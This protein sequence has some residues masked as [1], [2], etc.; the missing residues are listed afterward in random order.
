MQPIRTRFA[1]SPTGFLHI[2]GL[3]T[4]LFNVLFAKRYGGKFLLRI[5]DT[6][7]KRSEERFTRDILDSL[8]WLGLQHDEEIVYQSQRI[9][10]HKEIIEQLLDEQKAYKFLDPETKTEVVKL[11]FS[12]EL[13]S[14]KVVI[15]DL[16]QGRVEVDISDFEDMIIARSDGS[17]VYM[18]AVVIDD[19]DM[20]I[21][22]VIRGVDHLT[23]TVRQSLIFE[24]LDWDRPQFAHL[25]LIYGAD[26]KKLSKRHGAVGASEFRNKGFLPEALQN[27][28]LRLG[29][30]HGDDEIIAFEQAQQ[31]FNLNHISPSAAQF[32]YQKLN[33]LNNHYMQKYDYENFLP[34]VRPFI[35]QKYEKNGYTLQFLPYLFEALR[36][37]SHTLVDFVEKADFLLN[38]NFKVDIAN[39]SILQEKKV[40]LEQIYVVFEKTTWR[41]E[42]L[43]SA[44]NNFCK[45]KNIK[46]STIMPAIRICLS[47][48]MQSPELFDIMLGLYKDEC[49]TR[50]KNVIINL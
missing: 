50:I 42:D 2:G 22:H 15:D 19:H 5:E 1:P 16:I 10:R 17:S 29:W 20:Q 48:T 12:K 41:K 39:H 21:S 24:I 46:K 14:K 13:K 47:G 37:R 27:C 44:I 34:L 38:K 7:K 32:D 4:A 25:G 9:N 31:W 28:L 35:E 18:F 36:Q 30:S 49:L 8:S 40:L 3:R 26:S 33:F 45:E 23:N 43:K 11:K 6:D